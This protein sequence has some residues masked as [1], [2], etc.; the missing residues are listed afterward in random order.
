MPKKQKTK[1][2]PKASDNVSYRLLVKSE[3]DTLFVQYELGKWS[4]EEADERLD[5]L[6]DPY[7]DDVKADLFRR[8]DQWSPDHQV[9]MF[10]ALEAVVE[11]EDKDRLWAVVHSPEKALGA[12]M[13]ALTLLQGLGEEIDMKHPPIV[14]SPGDEDAADAILERTLD[15]ILEDMKRVGGAD[16][17]QEMMLV[18]DDIRE[19]TLDGVGVFFHFIESCTQRATAGASDFL[20]AL[21]EMASDPEVRAEAERALSALKRQGVEPKSRFAKAIQKDVFYKAYASDLN[22]IGVQQQLFMLWELERGKIQVFSFLM[23]LFETEGAIVLF[24]ALQGMGK[25]EFA[26]L[27]RE[28]KEHG[29]PMEEVSFVEARAI[30]EDAMEANRQEEAPF[31]EDFERYRRLVEKRILNVKVDPEALL[32]ERGK[33]TALKACVAEGFPALFSEMGLDNEEGFLPFPDDEEPFFFG[34]LTPLTPEQQHHVALRHPDGAF[35][36]GGFYLDKAD[37]TMADT[38]L[39]EFFDL[40]I[41]ESTEIPGAFCCWMYFDYTSAL[42]KRFSAYELENE[43]GIVIAVGREGKTGI[44]VGFCFYLNEE[45]EAQYGDDPYAALKD[46]FLLVK[47]EFLN[48]CDDTLKVFHNV[49]G[50]G[51][52]KGLKSKASQMLQRILGEPL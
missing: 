42:F 19:Q 11:E 39:G 28:S 27:M 16:E 15:R 3:L 6:L 30:V 5:D 47:Q 43:N 17:L 29:V 7:F 24:C 44:H 35:R 23:D 20:L 9:A 25:R 36:E 18:V 22:V 33:R 2:K 37:M 34:S 41:T 4:D 45:A 10:W 26:G 1:K 32:M 12:K 40:Y 14:L 52:Y 13:V 46:L 50:E 48:G 38:L 21:S 31:P 51:G 49:Y 8:L